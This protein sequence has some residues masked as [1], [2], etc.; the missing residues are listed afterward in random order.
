ML[1]GSA[2]VYDRSYTHNNDMELSIFLTGP[3]IKDIENNIIS[4]RKNRINISK[5]IG[6]TKLEIAIYILLF[7][8]VIFFIYLI[9][10]SKHYLKLKK[11]RKIKNNR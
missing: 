5:E 7:L 6:L 3:K 8:I 4:Q 2:N 11:I 9:N 1:Y 10:I